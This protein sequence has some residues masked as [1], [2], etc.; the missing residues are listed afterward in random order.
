M[1]MLKNENSDN[2]ALCPE[3]HVVRMALKVVCLYGYKQLAPLKPRH[4]QN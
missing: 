2:D 4:C 1:S 3:Q